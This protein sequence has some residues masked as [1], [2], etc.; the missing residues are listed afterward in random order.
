M[1]NEEQFKKYLESKEK[2]IVKLL[3]SDRFN[4][5]EIQTIC[6]GGIP[7][8]Y[9]PVC[10]KILLDCYPSYRKDVE[11]FEEALEEEYHSK[12]KNYA[13]NDALERQ[14]GIDVKRMGPS[15]FTSQNKKAVEIERE[16]Y[17]EF[18][19]LYAYEEKSVG[20]VQGMADMLIPFFKTFRHEENE[21][22]SIFY[23]YSSYMKNLKENLIG[24]QH[25][26]EI[27]IYRMVSILKELD[28]ELF[29][30]CQETNLDFKICVFRWFNVMFTREFEHKTYFIFLDTILTV[31]DVNIFAVYF[32]V[33][34]IMHFK[35]IILN[36]Q[37]TEENIMFLQNLKI[38][39]WD[40]DELLLIF[41]NVYVKSH[42]YFDK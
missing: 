14:I 10:Y 12:I 3:N 28:P 37:D 40:F 19:K 42:H 26:T 34:I 27:Q 21:K 32:S 8:K 36:N 2:K 41:S 30:F 39:N 29:E 24:Q 7:E 9:R 15:A 20:Y 22:S 33:C 1:K 6:W 11:E 31:E 38:I 4:K 13:N 18:L 25:G 16:M 23:T 35:Q 5:K 17:I